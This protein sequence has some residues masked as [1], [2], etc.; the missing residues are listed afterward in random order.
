LYV[1]HV[2]CSIMH[3]SC[4]HA[5]DCGW[6]PWTLGVLTNSRSPLH[7]PRAAPSHLLKLLICHLLRAFHL[8]VHFF[9][10]F[11]HL[12]NPVYFHV[13]FYFI[14]FL[15]NIFWAWLITWKINKYLIYFHSSILTYKHLVYIHNIKILNIKQLKLR[16]N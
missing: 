7:Y 13:I 4:E 12:F 3:V 15:K 9:S 14:F 6:F 8:H 5:W 10:L 1:R 2:T 16:I 11:F